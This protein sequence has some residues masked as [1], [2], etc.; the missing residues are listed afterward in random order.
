MRRARNK[1]RTHRAIFVAALDL[2]EAAGYERVTIGQICEAADVARATF[3]LHFPSKQ[4][5]LAALDRLL[6]AELTGRLE[7]PGS[8]AISECRSVVDGLAEV[9]PRRLRALLTAGVTD[10]GAGLHAV[11][12]D[13]VERGQRRGELRR[14][15]SPPLAASVILAGAG[16][17]VGSGRQPLRWHSQTRRNEL[18][19]GL[20]HGLRDQAAPEVASTVAAG[21][22]SDPGALRFVCYAASQRRCR[23]W[24]C[25][26][27][28]P[29]RPGPSTRPRRSRRAGLRAR[30]VLRLARP[31]GDVWIAMAAARSHRA[32]RRGHGGPGS[33]CATW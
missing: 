23:S 31:H 26:S 29:S 7:A 6:A 14:N 22:A 20:L 11:V 12:S 28:V 33:A 30:L 13:I 8:S 24:P 1:A 18:L 10:P 25:A 27:R 19:H 15:V 4:A 16:R 21:N 5:L 32:H 17:A 3:F 2:F 9:G